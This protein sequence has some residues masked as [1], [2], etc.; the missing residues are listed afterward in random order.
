MN[1]PAVC[2]LSQ[3]PSL[4]VDCLQMGP[5]RPLSRGQMGPLLLLKDLKHPKQ[6]PERN[7]QS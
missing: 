1:S 3:P 4:L 6:K 2:S 5:E 7:L